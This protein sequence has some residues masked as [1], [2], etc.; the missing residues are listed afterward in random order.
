MERCQSCLRIPDVAHRLHRGY[1]AICWRRLKRAR[2]GAFSR[3]S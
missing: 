1:C 2:Y 3:Q